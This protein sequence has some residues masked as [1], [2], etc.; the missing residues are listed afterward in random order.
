MNDEIILDEDDL[1]Q[2]KKEMKQYCLVCLWMEGSKV[3]LFLLIFGILNLVPEYLMALFILMLMRNNGGGIHCKHYISCFA[4]SLLVLIASIFIPKYINIS[5]NIMIVLLIVCAFLGHT[6]VPIVSENRPA[7]TDQLIVRCKRTT[8]II[9]L[10]YC[11]LVCICPKNLYLDIGSWTIF[12]HIFQLLIAK[13]MKGGHT[14]GIL[15]K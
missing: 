10:L 15:F 1:S 14:N 11:L 3:I 6:L 5:T 2:Y 4:V 8:F 12:I 7:P 9:I 13:F